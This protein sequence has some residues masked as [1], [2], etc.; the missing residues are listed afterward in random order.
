MSKLAIAF[1]HFYWNNDHIYAQLLKDCIRSYQAEF[2]ELAQ[3]LPSR[4]TL[5][6]FQTVDIWAF[7]KLS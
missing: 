2:C 6:Y 1:F 5:K 4:S 3:F 7:H